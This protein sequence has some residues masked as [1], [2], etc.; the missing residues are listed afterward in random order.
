VEFDE[1]KALFRTFSNPFEVTYVGGKPPLELVPHFSDEVETEFTE[2]NLLK[3]CA[4]LRQTSELGQKCAGM[5][6]NTFV[7]NL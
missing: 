2:D 1:D 5:F 6:G 7:K 4:F 3:F